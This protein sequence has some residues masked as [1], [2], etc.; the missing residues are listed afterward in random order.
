MRE[1]S[2]APEG[3]LFELLV[4]PG[5]ERRGNQ[6]FAAQLAHSPRSE[7]EGRTL[8]LSCCRKRERGTSGRWSSQLQAVVRRHRPVT[9][10]MPASAFSGTSWPP[11]T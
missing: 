3:H 1:L 7:A 8:G 9:P 4:L 11:A 10:G 6:E 5:A 2:R